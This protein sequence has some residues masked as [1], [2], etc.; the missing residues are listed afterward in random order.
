MNES[1]ASWVAILILNGESDSQKNKNESE[2]YILSKKE[3]T[4]IGR[5]QDC[6]FT[7][8]PKYSTVS[9]YHAKIEL[10]SQESEQFWQIQDLGTPNGTFVNNRRIKD[11]QRLKS[12]D[13]LTLGKTNAA[14]FTFE[15]NYI[16]IEKLNEVFRKKRL[17]DE[18]VVPSISDFENGEEK[19][20]FFSENLDRAQ[21]KPV[22]K[23]HEIVE[24]FRSNIV[25]I[26]ENISNLK[27]KSEQKSNIKVFTKILPGLLLAF[28]FLSAISF[29]IYRTREIS[30]VN[31]REEGLKSYIDNISRL[32]LD[33]KLG[34][35][36]PY[37]P[38]ARKARESANGQTLIKF[39]DLDGSAKGTLLRF[40]HGA[41]LIKIQ[42]QKLSK[43]WLANPYT[44]SNKKQTY[45]S[46]LDLNR[47]ELL[48][49]RQNK[50]NE[51]EFPSLPI[52]L[53]NQTGLDKSYNHNKKCSE[54]AGLNSL[55]SVC[56][57]VL[58]FKA[59]VYEKPFITPIQLSGADLTGVVLKDAPL[60]DI[61][62]EG[63]YISFQECKRDSSENF[64]EENLYRKPIHWFLRSKCRADFSGAGLQG[65][66]LF[67]S[68]LM[69]ANL[70]DAKLDYAD[71]RQADLRGANLTGASLNGAILKG[72]CFIA[73][74][75]EKNFP[76]KGPN[77]RPFNPLAEGMKPVSMNQSDILD[78][79]HFQ[80]CKNFVPS[81]ANSS[82]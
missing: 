1:S 78:P 9:R 34:S 6:Q 71:L 74:N 79:L 45:V 51:I 23:N 82:I 27:V 17:Y 2:P 14:N 40:L 8:S 19:T 55:N 73:E 31:N 18:T 41:K 25:G 60:E 36:N 32:L 53:S 61:N 29:W 52:F 65:A 57:L 15:W 75:W 35:L 64:L 43:E 20:R 66:R 47:K 39:K 21:E 37:D 72:A 80:E 33:K 46:E 59:Q 30:G 58:P 76:E 67:Q 24:A 77:G 11:S 4:Y 26:D 63:A 38:D 5:S 81:K 50:T 22:Q 69:G 49:L 62:L 48:Y 3:A 10:V 70:S 44:N 16:E 28:I 12:G 54:S 13:R 42:P 56:A 68:V 7:L